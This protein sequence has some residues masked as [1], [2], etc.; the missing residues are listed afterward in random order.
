MIKEA[1]QTVG[2]VEIYAVIG[3]MIFIVFFIAV[4]VW[5]VRLD[6]TYV[7]EMGELPLANSTEESFE[8]DRYNV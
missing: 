5:T 7:Q 2:S 1:L 6:K 8:G 4:I 3:L